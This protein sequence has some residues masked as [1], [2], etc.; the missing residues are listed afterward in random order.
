MGKT[1]TEELKL[2][3]GEVTVV[4]YPNSHIFKVDG[5][6]IISV[7]QATKHLDK[8]GA[9]MGWAT[10]LARE[11][12]IA[13]IERGMTVTIPDVVVACGLHRAFKQEA[14]DKGRL[15]HDY[16]EQH[17]KFILGQADAKPTMPEETQV[18]NGALAF[19]K[20]EKENDVEW[21][22]SEQ[23]IYSRKYE[24]C[25]ILDAKAKIRGNKKL[26]TTIDFKTGNGVYNDQKYQVSAYEKA[27]IE[28]TGDKY[29]DYRLLLR[30]DKE[31]ANFEEH[32]LMDC[33]KDF[34]AFL[35]GLAIEKRERELKNQLKKKIKLAF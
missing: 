16:C 21:I 29:T 9:L 25:G 17:I 35:G 2:Y 22:Q 26:F 11:S 10:K 13:R 32:E 7:T 33:D 12:L 24:Y 30:F 15:V 3:N 8:S 18:A 31:T 14:A 19:L 28:E 6:K 20:W 1:I 4:F 34:T 27:D 5:Q 23:K